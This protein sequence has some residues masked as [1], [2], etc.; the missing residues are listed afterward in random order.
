MIEKIIDTPFEFLQ[1]QITKVNLRF[2]KVD[3]ENQQVLTCD[4]YKSADEGYE[5]V[6]ADKAYVL[7]EQPFDLS[8]EEIEELAEI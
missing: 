1:E 8:E 3:S 7:G 2:I 5:L 4:L 6:Y